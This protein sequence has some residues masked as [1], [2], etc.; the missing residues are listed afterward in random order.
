MSNLQ[1]WDKLKTVP[2]TALKQIQAGRLKGKSDINPQWRYQI[3]TQTFGPCG[4]GWKF[5]IEKQ[6]IE[7][8]DNGEV[9][10]F[11]NINF[12]FKHENEWSEPIPANG[13]SMFVANERNGPYVSDE[14]YKMAITDALGTAMKMIGVAADVYA[15]FQ[16]SKYAKTEA[17]QTS[18]DQPEKP[19]L[20]KG[21]KLDEAIK[22][23]KGGGKM[24]IIEKK[25]M[26]NKEVRETLK[27][28][29]Q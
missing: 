15:G 3:L 21:E 25:Y 6:W 17:K 9:A 20:N 12:Y 13:G 5:T 11:A 14:C 10:S 27:S 28:A 2:Q 22:Y 24:E 26:I 8:Y 4:I 18:P 16:D 23:L 19:W 7:K 1:L 29:I